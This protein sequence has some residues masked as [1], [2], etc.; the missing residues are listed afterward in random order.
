MDKAN[1]KLGVIFVLSIIAILISGVVIADKGNNGNVRVIADTTSADDKAFFKSQGCKIVHELNDKTALSC[2][3]KV[4]SDLG[5]KADKVY[6]LL[7]LQACVQINA[8][9]VWTAGNE[10]FNVTVAV[11]DSGIDSAHQE[12]STL[13]IVGFDFVNNDTIPEDNHGHGTHVAGIVSAFGVDPD[14]R[15]VAPMVDLMVAKVCGS[16]GCYDSDIEAGIE[17][18][19]Y[20][21]AQVIS[22]SLGSYAVYQGADCD[23]ANDPVADKV[24]WAVDNGVVVAAAS[25]NDGLPGVSSPACA[26]KAIAVGAVNSGDKTASFTNAGDALDLLAPGV[27]I[28]SSLPGNSYDSKSGTSMATPHVSAVA[29]L[30]L[31][32]HPGYTVDDVKEAMYNTA[33]KVKGK[34][35]GAYGRVDALGAV[36]YV[37]GGGNGEDPPD[38]GPACP[39]GKRK[40]GKC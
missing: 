10:G 17:W 13:N 26:S 8:D 20:Q 23:W 37:I 39:P 5:L 16:A 32:A 25:G 35:G 1:T 14:A 21:G 24:N 34:H 29:A 38:E 22:M 40:Q 31:S 2:P 27:S 18:A 30:V 28:Y 6:R 15:G 19:V 33:A 9:D 4:A 11:L 12:F 3:K 7:D 36:N